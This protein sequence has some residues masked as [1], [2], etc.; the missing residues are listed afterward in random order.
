MP[1]MAADPQAEHREVLGAQIQAMG[2]ELAVHLR[3]AQGF[4]GPGIR[5]FDPE[6]VALAVLK[7]RIASQA[8][9][10]ALNKYSWFLP[11]RFSARAGRFLPCDGRAGS[12]AADAKGAH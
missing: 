8:S 11:L 7:Q 5:L 12:A 1:Q 6:A 3:R 4:G 9:L 10:S 2:S